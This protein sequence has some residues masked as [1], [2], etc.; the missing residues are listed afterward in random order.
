MANSIRVVQSTLRLNNCV[1]D[2]MTPIVL[3][4]PLISKLQ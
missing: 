1:P 4:T 2:R 3:K